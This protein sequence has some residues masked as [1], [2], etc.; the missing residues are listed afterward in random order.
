MSRFGP[1]G[2]AFVYKIEHRRCGPHRSG[3]D[4]VAVPPDGFAACFNLL[5]C[6]RTSGEGMEMGGRDAICRAFRL[7]L[8]KFMKMKGQVADINSQ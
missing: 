4:D 8:G 3:S 5:L 7:R 6:A 2:G 1:G